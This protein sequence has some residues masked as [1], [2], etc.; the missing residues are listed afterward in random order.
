MEDLFTT[1]SERYFPTRKDL[2]RACPGHPLLV[3]RHDGHICSVNSAALVEIGVDKSNVASV[4]K[5]CGI[6]EIRVDSD[7]EPTGVFTEGATALPLDHVPVPAGER[8]ETGAIAFS[9]ELA[10]FGITTCGGILQIGEEGI[11]GKAGAV[12]IP[13]MEQFIRKGIIEPDFVFL[14]YY[15]QA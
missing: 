4:S 8:L 15:Q 1:P 9:K 10:S 3:L 12:E 7:G 6:G 11:A 5:S 13:L 2:D 14:H